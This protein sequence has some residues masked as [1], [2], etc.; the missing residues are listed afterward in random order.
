ME[1]VLRSI[2]DSWGR[3]FCS[4]RHAVVHTRAGPNEI[5]L[6]PTTHM[7]LVMLSP[8]LKREVA[9]GGSRRLMGTAPAG[10]LEIVPSGADLFA[11]WATEK[12][13]MLFLLDDGF[14]SDLAAAEIRGGRVA[15]RSPPLGCTDRRLHFLA[16]MARDELA[17]GESADPLCLESIAVLLSAH[18]LRN[19]S[20]GPVHGPMHVG[21]LTPR[22]TRRVLDYIEG[23]LAADLSVA[24]LAGIAG[25]SPGHFLRAFR[26]AVGQSPHRYVVGRRLARAEELIE[27]SELSLKA[28]AA[29]VG[30]CSNSHMT[31]AMRRVRGHT[32]NEVRHESRRSL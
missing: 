26:T 13:N 8:Q 21:G 30:F 17:L 18:L 32:P 4:V 19:H 9:L 5:A 22:T 6:T 16:R 24:S 28:V 20:G 25:L 14:L 31:A 15:L 27:N 7:A 3:K 1:G 10:S 23:N 29:A 2:P 11:K 12:E